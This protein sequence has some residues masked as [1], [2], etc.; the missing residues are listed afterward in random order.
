MQLLGYLPYIESHERLDKT[1]Y[2]EN[3]KSLALAV[4]QTILSIYRS[5]PRFRSH[6]G[7]KIRKTV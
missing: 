6:A 4:G 7:R 5:E 2:G 3:S 1:V